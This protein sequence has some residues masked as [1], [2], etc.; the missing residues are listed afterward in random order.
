[1]GWIPELPA[2]HRE[3]A[4]DGLQHP[5]RTAH[6]RSAAD[7]REAIET[8]SNHHR[9]LDVV[10]SDF[11]MPERSGARLLEVVRDLRPDIPFVLISGFPD[12][13]DAAALAR[14]DDVELLLKPFTVTALHTLLVSILGEPA[15]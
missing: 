15:T 13:M 6:D 1:M 10:V 12:R 3:P 11:V 7:G 8:F 9:D 14:R 4:E 5:T 2:R